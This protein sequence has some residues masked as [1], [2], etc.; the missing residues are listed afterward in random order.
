MYDNEIIAEEILQLEKEK[1][2]IEY[3]AWKS[4]IILYEILVETFG[5]EI[6]EKIS[7][8]LIDRTD[9]YCDDNGGNIN[10]NKSLIREDFP[11]DYKFKDYFNE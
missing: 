4:Y 3:R 9:E 10:V 8:K 1:A 2:Y 6:V 7:D 11:S 5:P